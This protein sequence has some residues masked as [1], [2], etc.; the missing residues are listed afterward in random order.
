MHM[1]NQKYVWNW[2]LKILLFLQQ[3]LKM[4][5][6]YFNNRHTSYSDQHEISEWLLEISWNQVCVRLSN[7]SFSGSSAGKESTCNAGNLSSFPGSGNSTG[8]GI[9]YVL[10]CSWVSF[11]A[12]LVK[13]LPVIR[14]SWIWS[15]GWEDPLEMGKATHSSILAW[16]IPW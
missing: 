1:K 12:Q 7:F 4:L 8:E 10:Q 5:S 13:N 9:D 16:R 6:Y 2:C 3:N 14:D 11:V 15:L